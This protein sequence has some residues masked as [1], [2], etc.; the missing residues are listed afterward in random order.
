MLQ[1]TGS[2]RVGHNLATDNDNV[3]RSGEAKKVTPTFWLLV[4]SCFPIS[5][6]INFSLLPANSDL[7]GRSF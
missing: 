6:P 2:K 5:P 4:F 1:S 3:E 7:Q